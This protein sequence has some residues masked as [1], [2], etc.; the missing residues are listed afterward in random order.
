LRVSKLLL[1]TITSP[2]SLDNDVSKLATNLEG[3]ISTERIDDN[4][5]IAPLNAFQTPSNILFL[6]E[7]DDDC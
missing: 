3:L 4:N 5:F 7:G 6:I 2:L 1:I